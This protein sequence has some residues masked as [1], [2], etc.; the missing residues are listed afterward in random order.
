[1][2]DSR[3]CPD[4]KAGR[5]PHGTVRRATGAGCRHRRAGRAPPH[6]PGRR[7][8]ASIAFDSR[9]NGIVRRPSGTLR[10]VGTSAM[11]TT[12]GWWRPR[13]HCGRRASP[14]ERLRLCTAESSSVRAHRRNLCHRD[15]TTISASRGIGVHGRATQERA[16]LEG[17][18]PH[19]CRQAPRESDRPCSSTR[20]GLNPPARRPRTRLRRSP[21]AGNVTAA[22]IC[23]IRIRRSSSS[24]SIT[25]T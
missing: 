11:T 21:T 25:A 22:S 16:R 2:N 15:A 7:S 17:H 3:S 1:M 14:F 24:G 6:P 19:I 12:L 9:G 5:R 8:S 4:S 13:R 10:A 20:R 18:A 23:A